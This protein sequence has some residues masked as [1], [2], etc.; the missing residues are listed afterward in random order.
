MGTP[1]PK[2]W[3]ELDDAKFYCVWADVFEMAPPPGDCDNAWISEDH[4]CTT[5]AF[6]K[7]WIAAGKECTVATD[8]WSGAV[9]GVYRITHI[10]GPY[11]TYLGCQAEC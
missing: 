3:P 10:H 8:P 11:D 9:T 6:L 1:V 4:S 5:G 2:D 7:A